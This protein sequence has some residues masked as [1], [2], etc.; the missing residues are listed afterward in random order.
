MIIAFTG[1]PGS[2]KSYDAA[3]KI[4]D[5]LR[6]GRVVYTNIRGMDSPECFEVIKAVT[7]LAD[8]GLAYHLRFLTPQQVPEFWLHVQPGSM[9]VLDEVQ[10]DF[11]ARDWQSQKNVQFNAWA[12]THRH[13]GYDVVLIT[14]SIQRIDT[15]VRALI[16]WTYIYRKMNFFGS[17]IQKRYLCYAYGGEEVTGPPL[18][19]STR[20]YDSQIFLC[21][22]SYVAKDVKELSVMKHINI[23]NHPIFWAI[24]LVFGYFIYMLFHSG[25]IRGDLFG[26]EKNI[27]YSEQIAKRGS[28]KAVAS[29]SLHPSYLTP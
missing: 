4:I 3:R 16:E 9:I 5:N 20:A 15:S 24:P 2:G 7:G 27:K 22:Q 23:L 28:G 12:S 13:H 25:M 19:K 18:S 21:Y 26:V 8:F 1:T 11:N 10:N 17:L 6:L 29:S 14:Q